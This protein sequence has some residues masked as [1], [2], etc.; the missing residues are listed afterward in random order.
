MGKLADILRTGKAPGFDTK[1][2]SERDPDKAVPR[3]FKQLSGN[4][5][6]QFVRQSG[7][8]VD[9]V[10]RTWQMA[11]VGLLVLAAGSNQASDINKGYAFTATDRVTN[12]KLNNLVDAATINTQFFTD[13]SSSTPAASD[14]FIFARSGNFY[15]TTYASL[16]RD[17]SGLI[18]D[19][20]DDLTPAINDF[21]L[22]YDSSAEALAKASLG[23]LVFTN[24]FLINGRAVLTNLI[25]STLLLGYDTTTGTYGKT[26]LSNL[27]QQALST[28]ALTNLQFLA[29]PA[30]NDLLMVWDDD[31][32][33]NKATT[34]TALVTNLPTITTNLATDTVMLITSNGPALISLPDLAATM[35]DP[36]VPTNYVSAELTI[37]YG[38]I[39]DTAHAIG[40]QPQSVRAVLVC[41]TAD[42]S[43]YVPG[44]E[45][46]VNSSGNTGYGGR[47]FVYGANS[48]NVWL[49]L[50]D[51][52]GDSALVPSV[53]N[54][55]NPVG[56]ATLTFSNWRAKIYATRYQ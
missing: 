23:A 4:Q 1:T 41:K 25:G 3:A 14:I 43:G 8:T 5:V 18:T 2:V 56:A 54:K 50:L 17:Y 19:Q 36:F 9:H 29:T 46:D 38:L 15:R 13:K 20:G 37:A 32:G 22:T 42:A 33:T 40:A 31:A 44:D 34:F 30:T 6:R 12:T 11:L 45:L 39:A 10:K 35:V 49:S 47:V 48:T 24:D 28:F 51:P 16:I 26:T 53:L 55:T 7:F 27:A 52:G 21:V